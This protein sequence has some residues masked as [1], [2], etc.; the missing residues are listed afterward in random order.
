MI[1]T[2]LIQNLFLPAPIAN[3]KNGIVHSTLIVSIIP[4]II[5]IK[6]VYEKGTVN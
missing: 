6:T 2:L 3:S 5:S 1:T 4:E